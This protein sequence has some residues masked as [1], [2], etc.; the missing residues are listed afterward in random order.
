MDSGYGLSLGESYALVILL[1]GT[2]F[3]VTG[4]VYII[5]SFWLTYENEWTS[6]FKD[7]LADLK[8]E[9]RYPE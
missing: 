9:W 1:G 7:W 5:L 4:L 8:R 6:H 3:A 2:V